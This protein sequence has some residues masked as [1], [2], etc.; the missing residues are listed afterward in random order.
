MIW[1]RLNALKKTGF[2]KPKKTGFKK[3][4]KPPKKSLKKA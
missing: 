1:R 4:L 3:P 2:K